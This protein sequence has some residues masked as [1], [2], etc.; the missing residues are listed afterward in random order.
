[1]MPTSNV[2][3]PGNSGSVGNAWTSYG[4]HSPCGMGKKTAG[5][6]KGTTSAG[7]GPKSRSYMW[8][9]TV[10]PVNSIV[11]SF[12]HFIDWMREF[13][14]ESVG[15]SLCLRYRRPEPDRYVAG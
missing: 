11:Q 15:S 8:S 10:L 5:S 6:G 14:G 1:M 9:V 3:S 4:A 12:R 13:G 2:H 7:F